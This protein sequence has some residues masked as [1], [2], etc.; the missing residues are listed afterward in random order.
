MT[1]VMVMMIYSFCVSAAS[2]GCSATNDSSGGPESSSFS[3]A[4]QS[5]HHYHYCYH[6]HT[7]QLL[8]ICGAHGS[9]SVPVGGKYLGNTLIHP[10]AD[11]VPADD[12][13]AAPIDSKLSEPG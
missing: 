11:G 7:I 3:S 5:H 6:Y 13:G 12:D 9:T 2:T 1:S 4:I 10:C 8:Y